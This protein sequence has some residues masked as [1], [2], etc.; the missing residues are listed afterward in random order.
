MQKKFAGPHVARGPHFDHVCYRLSCGCFEVYENCH[1]LI[2]KFYKFQPGVFICIDIQKVIDWMND[3][4][5]WTI[6]ILIWVCVY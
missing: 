2:H 6:C 3:K 4:I 5:W 1:I